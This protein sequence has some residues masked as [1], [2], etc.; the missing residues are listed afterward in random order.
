MKAQQ[1]VG[2]CLVDADQPTSRQR[3]D[4]L[5]STDYGLIAARIV[6]VSTKDGST[7]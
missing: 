4:D 6:E 1:T 7:S 3:P 5:R 2:A